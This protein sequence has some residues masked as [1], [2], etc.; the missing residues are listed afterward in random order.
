MPRHYILFT[1]KEIQ[2]LQK[3]VHNCL[4][5]YYWHQYCY[6]ETVICLC[7][8]RQMSNLQDT[9]HA[10]NSWK[11][12]LQVWKK[13]YTDIIWKRLSKTLVLNLN[14]KYQ[15]EFMRYFI[16]KQLVYICVCV[17]DIQISQL[18]LLKK[19]RNYGH[20]NSNEHFQHLGP[21]PAIRNQQL[22]KKC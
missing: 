10:P 22:L 17:Y 1:I 2:H 20:S 11:T 18:Y 9:V 16:F 19:P 6:S 14:Q 8:L 21:F 4:K 5:E 12:R 7:R 15:Y 13:G 3:Y